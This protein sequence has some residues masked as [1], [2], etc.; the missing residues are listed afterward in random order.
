MSAVQD[1]STSIGDLAAAVLSVLDS[2]C[3]IAPFSRSLPELDFATAYAVTAELRRLREKRGEKHAGRK[4]GFTNRNIWAQYGVDCPIWG[5]VWNTTLH[6][7]SHVSGSFPLARM[8]EPQIEPEIVFKLAAAP[9]QDMS[10]TDLLSCIEWV[11]LGYE[12]VQS[13]FPGWKFKAVDTVIGAGLHGVLLIGDTRQIKPNE[14]PQW[15]RSLA[16]FTIT[17]SSR[18]GEVDRGGGQNVLGSPLLAFRHLAALL[19][20]DKFNP[21]LA[22]GEIVTTGTLTRAHPIAPGQT[23]TTAVS[24][25][26]LEDISLTL[27]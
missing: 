19:A 11:A 24:G 4:I 8:M 20:Q 15:Q 22:P 9:A 12:I 2:Q 7:L 5:D 10:E 14:F 21:P 23:W 6:N 17:L 18:D 1:R 25:I 3:Q 16:E 26:A 27:C 13:P